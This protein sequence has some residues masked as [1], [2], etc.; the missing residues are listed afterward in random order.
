MVETRQVP[1]EYR[2]GG[3]WGICQMCGF[4]HRLAEL[5]KD[6][7][8][9]LVCSAD[10]DPKP[11]LMNPPRMMAEQVPVRDPSPEPPDT[12]IQTQVTPESL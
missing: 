2:P 4:K 6:W 3:V 9:L 7:R 5:R 10:Y 12:F 11:D 1:V 8:G